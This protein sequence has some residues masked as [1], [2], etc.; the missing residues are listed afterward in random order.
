MSTRSPL[1]TT[2][3][4]SSSGSSRQYNWLSERKG[5]GR[6]ERACSCSTQHH[7]PLPCVMVTAVSANSPENKSNLY[8]LN[9]TS[10]HAKGPPKRRKSKREENEAIHGWNRTTPRDETRR[11]LPHELVGEGIAPLPSVRV[12]LPTLTQLAR[13]CSFPPQGNMQPPA[14][15]SDTTYQPGAVH[16]INTRQRF[17]TYRGATWLWN[18][19]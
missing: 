7:S 10:P 4:G 12:M 3:S 16:F 15:V 8:P 2:G 18:R 13:R 9:S 14:L 19:L 1:R 11:V 17:P 6:G 5:R